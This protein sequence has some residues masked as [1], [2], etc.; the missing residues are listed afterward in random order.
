[1]EECGTESRIEE[2]VFIGVCSECGDGFV[3]E[4]NDPHPEALCA[5]CALEMLFEE[6]G[7]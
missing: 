2:T 5:V 4:T 3:Y 6:A 1:M 7:E